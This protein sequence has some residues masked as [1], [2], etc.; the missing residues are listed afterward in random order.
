M[1]DNKA[2]ISR[3]DFKDIKA[4]LNHVMKNRSHILLPYTLRKK[5]MEDNKATISRPDFKYIIEKI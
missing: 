2:T 4:V 3:P 5:L 1:E